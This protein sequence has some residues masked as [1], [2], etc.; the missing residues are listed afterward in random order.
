MLDIKTEFSRVQDFYKEDPRQQTFNALICG[1][2]GSGK[3]YL[4]KT[5][6]QPVWIDSFDPGGTKCIRTAIQ[7]PDRHIYADTRW[8]Q[9]DP[10]KPSVY[11]EWAKEMNRRDAAGFFNE[12]GTYVIDSL[13]TLGD[14]VMNEILR[15]AGIAG[16]AP[17]FT[18]D[19]T[20]QKF[21]LMNHIKALMNLPCN[22]ILTGHLESLK[23]EVTGDLSFRLAAT[24]QARF[25]IPLLFD[26]VYVTRPKEGSKSITYQ[27]LTQSTG[28]YLARSRLAE[29]GKIE[30]LIEPDITKLLRKVG[31]I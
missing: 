26:E 2:S 11:T 27:L 15:R 8:E 13:T 1:E 6:R 29:G 4:L 18:K 7:D 23:D 19:Y 3:T 17:R 24:G 21:L 20:P 28:R 16:Q 25:R 9:E 22:F 14:A 5:C 10:K 30:T 31:I 12:I